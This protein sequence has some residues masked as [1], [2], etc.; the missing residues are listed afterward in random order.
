MSPQAIA[1][2]IGIAI[3]IFVIVIMASS[4][5]YVVHPGYRG[6]QVTLGKVSPAFKQDSFGLTF[7]FIFY[8][9]H[10]IA[11][12]VYRFRLF[13]DRLGEGKIG[14][15]VKLRKGDCFENLA[16]S[17]SAASASLATSITELKSLAGALT[18]KAESLGDRELGEQVATINRALDRYSVESETKDVK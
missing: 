9:T 14:T 2:L 11:G 5:T 8:Y 13:F 6:V 1:R 7:G 18:Q 15:R 4:G 12:P 17:V 3:L 10:R 16:H